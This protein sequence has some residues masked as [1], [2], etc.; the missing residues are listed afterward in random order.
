MNRL[1]HTIVL[2]RCL[3]DRTGEA[4]GGQRSEGEF[5]ALAMSGLQQT[6]TLP[7]FSAVNT[8]FLDPI[9]AHEMLHIRV[10][11]KEVLK[12]LPAKGR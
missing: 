4:A 3:L 7:R 5:T 6:S 11:E 8:D 10:V 2:P 1:R 12:D 9:L